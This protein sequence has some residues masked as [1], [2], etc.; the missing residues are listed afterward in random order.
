M[1]FCSGKQMLNIH[2]YNEY[3]TVFMQVT[4]QLKKNKLI[5]LNNIY[6]T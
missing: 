2:T 5:I 6:N 3:E 1:S 4:L